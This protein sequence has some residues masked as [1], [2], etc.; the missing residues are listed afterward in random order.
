MAKN[1]AISIGNTDNKLTQQE[2]SEFVEEVNLVIKEEAAI[3]FFGGAPNWTPW[4][5]VAWIAEV[6]DDCAYLL[7]VIAN[8]RKRYRQDSAFVFTGEGMF[9]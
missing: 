1:I 5:N 8:I 3:H 2:W 6:D 9:I 7:T 4:Q